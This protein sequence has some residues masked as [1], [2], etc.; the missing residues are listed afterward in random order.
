[1]ETQRVIIAIV[2]SFLILVGYQKLFMPPPPVQQPKPAATPATP[3]GEIS[4]PSAEVPVPA[5]PPAPTQ[6]TLSRPARTITVKTALY[7]AVFSEDGGGLTSLRLHQYRETVASDSPPKELV[8]TTDPSDLPLAVVWNDGKAVRRPLLAAATEKTTI[9]TENGRAQLTMRGSLPS[10]IEIIRTLSF[11]DDLYLIDMTVEV[12]NRGSVPQTGAPEILLTN[13]PFSAEANGFL[14]SGP[15][16]LQG[17]KL[18]EIKVDDLEEG[19]KTFSGPLQWAAYEG[20]YFLCGVLPRTDEPPTVE[21]RLVGPKTVR[22]RVAMPAATIAPGAGKRYRFAAYGGPKEIRTLKAADPSLA[23]AVNFG[24]WDFLA[25]PTLHLLNFLYRYVH[26]YGVAIILVTVLIKLLFWPIAQKGMRSMKTMQ[27]LQPKMAKLREK[28]ADD[29]ERLNQEMMQLYKTYKVNPL[30]G[31]L[32]M[33]LQI[34][35]F[36]ALYKVLLQTIELRHAPFMLWINDLS[37]P[38]RLPIGVDIPYL[39]GLPVLTILMGA[40]MYV[41]QMMTPATG[42]PTQQKV[43]KFLPLVFTFMFLNFASGLVLYWLVNNL[44]SIVQQYMINRQIQAEDEA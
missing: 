42:D 13:R 33:L 23:Q 28:Y 16:V 31:C 19:V 29:R 20:P 37:A 7:T 5:P 40:S 43:M 3:P 35:V 14:F 27:K 10:G 26:N 6:D 36:F 32:P 34:P 2:L 17:G 41:Q 39:G 8:T 44:L 4:S 24:F 38:D 25:K 15:A 11:R 1:M 9:T 30:S 21:F 22:T 12:V 18:V